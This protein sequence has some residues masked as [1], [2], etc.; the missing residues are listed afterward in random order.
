MKKLP[1]APIYYIHA[2]WMGLAMSGGPFIGAVGNRFGIRAAMSLAAAI[3]LPVIP[4]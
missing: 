4:L 2:L 1:A 3:L